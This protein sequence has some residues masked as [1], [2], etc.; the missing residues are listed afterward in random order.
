MAREYFPNDEAKKD[1]QQ[2]FAA[3]LRTLQKELGLSTRELADK[4]YVSEPTIISWRVPSV[5]HYPYVTTLIKLCLEYNI[6]ADWLLLG[7]GKMIYEE[8]D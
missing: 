7:R 5:A 8:T 2:Q 6:S 1:F 3:R 4:I